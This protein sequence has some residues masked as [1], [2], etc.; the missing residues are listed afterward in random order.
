MAT[1][2]ATAPTAKGTWMPKCSASLPAANGARP[3]PRK[4][5]KPYAAEATGRSTGDDEHDRLG[6]Q[7]VV[8]A[9]EGAA[10]DHRGDETATRSA[11]IAMTSEIDGEAG[12][13]PRTASGPC[14]NAACSRGAPITEKKRDQQ[15][16]AEE[17]EAELD[18]R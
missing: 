18:R 10:D 6:G 9:D 7:R 12:R 4:R 15:A 5:T 8:D 17:D 1:T 3:P 2:T 11:Q 16:P 13:A 14:R